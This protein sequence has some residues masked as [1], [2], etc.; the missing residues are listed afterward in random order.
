MIDSTVKTVDLDDFLAHHG[1]LGMQWGKRNGPPY[2]LDAGAHSPEEKKA[3]YQK[4]IAKNKN[5]AVKYKERAA[6]L[7]VKAAKLERKRL[8]RRDNSMGFFSR[9]RRANRKNLKAAK[10]ER[11]AA[12]N[13]KR[14]IDYED[15]LSKLQE[16]AQ[17]YDGMELFGAG[18]DRLSPKDKR[19]AKKLNKKRLKNLEKA[20]K[21]REKNKKEAEKKEEILRKG[22]AKDLYKIK[23][24]LSADDYNRA[25]TRLDNENKLRERMNTNQKLKKERFDTAMK[26]LQT[27]STASTNFITLYNN[28]AKIYNTFAKPDT[29]MPLIAQDNNNNNKK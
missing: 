9:A 17:I 2:P 5:S 15:K 18:L 26:T 11:K 6:K 19:A 3:H 29:P 8:R 20:R 14:V 7:R 22:S 10:L 1:I 25:F 28:G 27:V 13:E 12:R 16:A 4:S 23:D 21:T 24:K